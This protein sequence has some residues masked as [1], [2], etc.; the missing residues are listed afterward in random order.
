ML[1]VISWSC[2]WNLQV[3]LS[4]Y[5][6]LVFLPLETLL[7]YME[8]LPSNQRNAWKGRVTHI[9]HLYASMPRSNR[10]I[11]AHAYKTLLHLCQSP[12]QREWSVKAT[13]I[14]V[15]VG[16]AAPPAS[17]LSALNSWAADRTEL[18]YWTST[19]KWLQLAVKNGGKWWWGS[20]FVCQTCQNSEQRSVCGFNFTQQNNY[21]IN[22]L[23]GYY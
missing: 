3:W 11:S 7:P 9:S 20:Q 4:Y 1:H 6:L 22:H 19:E 13:E 18:K 8:W 17:C 10:H 21:S 12:R 2:Q 16:E 5:I 23:L 14:D 15:L